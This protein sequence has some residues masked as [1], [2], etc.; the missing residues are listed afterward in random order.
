MD[1]WNVRRR[2]EILRV[3]VVKN[4]EFVFTQ[5]PG[6]RRAELRYRDRQPEKGTTY[7]YVRVLQRDPEKPAGDPEITW[8][9]PFF[10]A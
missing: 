8:A 6:G 2:V 10:E 4:G 7:Y 5:R 3:D 1:R 9:S